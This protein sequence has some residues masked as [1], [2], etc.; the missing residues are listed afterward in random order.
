MVHHP[1]IRTKCQII[2]D[3]NYVLSFADELEERDCS[4][5]FDACCFGVIAKVSDVRVNRNGTVTYACLWG[6]LCLLRD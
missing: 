6:K 3:G 5:P 1:I 2:C 4:A